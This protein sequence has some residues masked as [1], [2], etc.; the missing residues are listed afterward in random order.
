[1]EHGTLLGDVGLQIIG[2]LLHAIRF[3]TGGKQKLAKLQI[4]HRLGK[5]ETKLAVGGVGF[6]DIIVRFEAAKLRKTVK[7]PFLRF[8]GDR[9]EVV[10]IEEIDGAAKKGAFVIQEQDFKTAASLDKDIQTAIG[11]LFQH[12]FH[13]RGAARIDDTLLTGLYHPKFLALAHDLPEHLLVP[14]FKNMKRQGSAG[15]KHQGQW[16]QRQ[17]FLLHVYY[18]GFY[19]KEMLGRRRT[20]GAQGGF[21]AVRRRCPRKRTQYRNE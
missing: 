21:L 12:S 16:E 20:G 17:Q 10:V 13:R 14:V 11:I 7:S 8:L 2:N 3:R 15:K 18:Y 9:L 1:M 6:A 5:A 4:R 19:S